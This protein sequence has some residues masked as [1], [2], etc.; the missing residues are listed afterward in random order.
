M[1]WHGYLSAVKCKWFAYGPADATATPSSLASLKSRL[2]QPFWLRITQFVLK[3]RPLN[4]RFCLF[5]VRTHLTATSTVQDRTMV[6][7]TGIRWT[8]VS[9]NLHKG[10]NDHPWW[11]LALLCYNINKLTY[12]PAFSALMPLAGWQEG[13]PSCKRYGQDGGGGHWLVRMEWCPAG[14]SVGLPL[15]IFPCT[16]KSR[17]SLLAPAHPGGPGKRAVKWLCMCVCYLLSQ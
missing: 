10:S 6:S 16:I 11:N 14:W 12:L 1:G 17:S 9:L 2:L 4:E 7:G 15:L 5:L 8:T 3:K 13:H